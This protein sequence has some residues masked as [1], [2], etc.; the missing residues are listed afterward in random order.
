MKL[1]TMLLALAMMAMGALGCGGSDEGTDT[2]VQ[3]EQAT[4]GEETAPAD[5]TEAPAADPAANPCA[6][7]AENPCGGDAAPTE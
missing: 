2:A 1:G 3:D 6:G 7:G 5:T 4:G